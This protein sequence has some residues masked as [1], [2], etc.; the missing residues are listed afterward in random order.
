MKKL[1][2]TM[3]IVLLSVAVFTGCGPDNENAT[4][5]PLV[6]TPSPILTPAV[7]PDPETSPTPAASPTSE[8][9]DNLDLLPGDEDQNGAN[10]G[11]NNADGGL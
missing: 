2:I 5:S 11:N 7:S 3:V 8:I 1:L 4:P 6:P 10:G 9:D